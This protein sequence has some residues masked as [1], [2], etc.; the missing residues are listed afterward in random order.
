MAINFGLGGKTAMGVPINYEKGALRAQGNLN[1]LQFIALVQK[2]WAESHPDIPIRPTQ[3]KAYAT[4]PV[5]VYK[6][7][8][9]RPHS[10]EPKPKQRE[11]VVNEG[12]NNISI[13][14]GQKFENLVVF[15]VFTKADPELAEAIIEAFEDFMLEYTP[16]FKRLGLSEIVY[17]RRIPDG[18]G[19]RQA[20]DVEYRGV[21]YMVTTEK[22]RKVDIDTVESIVVKARTFL[23]DDMIHPTVLSATP[24]IPIEITDNF[25][26]TPNHATPN[27]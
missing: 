15:Q 2:L 19:S 9:R 16:I 4:Y 3:A 1:Y 25:N 24:N 23:E 20:E 6:L 14:Y 21:A 7:E 13:V 5:I 12:E 8:I 27:H 22:L 10:G 17:S 26:A 18:E 11:Q